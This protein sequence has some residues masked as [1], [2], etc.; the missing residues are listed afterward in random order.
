MLFNSI[1]FLIFLPLVFFLYWFV[2]QKHLKSQ[3]YFILAISYLFYGW[4]D[5]RYLILLVF[6]S[7]INY[8]AGV[9]LAN[10]QNIKSRKVVLALS[11]IVSLGVLCV[12]KYFN[13][14]VDNFISAFSFNWHPFTTENTEHYSPS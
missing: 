3:N 9:R 2:F 6:C 4:W 5:W 12:F 10:N 7:G 8:L 11:C 1:A 14:F 13:F